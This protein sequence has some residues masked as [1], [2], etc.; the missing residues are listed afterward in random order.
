MRRLPRVCKGEFSKY[1]RSRSFD[2]QR[3]EQTKLGASEIGSIL[4]GQDDYLRAIAHKTG[5]IKF[6]TTEQMEK[7]KIME[8]LSFA[9]YE[10]QYRCEITAIYPNKY[11]NG[12]DGYNYFKKYRGGESPIGSTID[13]WLLKTD[14][15]VELLELKYSENKKYPACIK[16]YNKYG[17]PLRYKYFLAI[18]A[19]A[20]AQIANTGVDTCNVH[21]TMSDGNK[22]CVIKRN[23]PFIDHMFSIAYRFLNELPLYKEIVGDII[24][25]G[26]SEDEYIDALREAL[27]SRGASLYGELDAPDYD[28]KKALLAY[29]PKQKVVVSEAEAGV[30]EDLL[31]QIDSL[32]KEASQIMDT[33]VKEK[34]D[35][36]RALQGIL[37]D[38]FPFID[39]S[40]MY[41]AGDII[42][43]FTS[44]RYTNIIDRLNIIGINPT[45]RV[46]EDSIKQQELETQPQNEYDY[47]FTQEELEALNAP[48]VE[49][50]VGEFS[51]TTYPKVIRGIE[52]I[53]EY[54]GDAEAEEI[55]DTNNNSYTDDAN[56]DNHI[57]SSCKEYNMSF[58]DDIDYNNEYDK[59][60][61]LEEDDMN[62]IKDNPDK[63]R[64]EQVKSQIK[65]RI[66]ESVA[67]GSVKFSS[68]DLY[69]LAEGYGV[70][71]SYFDYLSPEDLYLIL[72]YFPLMPNRDDDWGGDIN[73]YI[74]VYLEVRDKYAEEIRLF[75]QA[76]LEKQAQV[77]FRE[78]EALRF[79]DRQSKVS[80]GANKDREENEFF[81]EGLDFTTHE[82][83]SQQI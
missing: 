29:L 44:D 50:E 16:D 18:Y 6:K 52:E 39:D 14:G 68:K 64:V 8:G 1:S 34:K 57:D 53:R 2:E 63:R 81:G 60:N 37:R 65:T 55:Y 13:G 27:K 9:L 10:R 19:Q 5:L 59:G 31:I 7:G 20:Q 69:E 25:S 21:F 74:R 61:L 62:N 76:E 38:Q 70:L 42:F 17:N 71:E 24:A 35:K 47:L 30:L 36:A 49:E 15:T 41:E 22:R 58:F 23:Q 82:Q 32:E 73:F 83:E 40:S 79:T 72:K 48:L 75:R 54:L 56:N 45:V 26:C 33:V 12:V 66:K 43:T 4:L 78:S 67:E 51:T 28:Y 77:R 80:F 46:E 3:R 11:K